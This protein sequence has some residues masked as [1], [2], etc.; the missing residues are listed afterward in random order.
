MRYQMAILF[1]PSKFSLPWPTLTA[2]ARAAHARQ[3][4]WNH[5][6]HRRLIRKIGGLGESILA[7]D[8]FRSG[9]VGGS[10]ASIDCSSCSIALQDA[11]GDTKSSV[12]S[13]NHQP[14]TDRL[15]PEHISSLSSSSTNRSTSPNGKRLGQANRD[16]YDEQGVCFGFGITR[17]RISTT[18]MALPASVISCNFLT[19]RD[20]LC[21]NEEARELSPPRLSL[22]YSQKAHAASVQLSR[23][24]SQAVAALNA[25]RQASTTSLAMV[26]SL[27]RLTAVQVQLQ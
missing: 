27:G 18:S 25:I 8:T 6:Q 14:E 2:Q 10:R 19:E 1:N 9:I 22:Q 24:D 20:F 12:N 26:C 13:C 11:S 16:N 7:R 3:Q 23:E 21:V 15:L 4:D 5:A 17:A